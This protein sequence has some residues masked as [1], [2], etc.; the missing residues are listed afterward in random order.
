MAN[1][2]ILDENRYFDSDPRIRSV[3]R[4]LYEDIKDLPIVC[5]HGHV[6]P[7]LFSNNAPFPDPTELILI[8]DH[9]I[10]RMLYSRGIKLEDMGV[11]TRDATPN[12]SRES[13]RRA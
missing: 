10:F 7:R 2:L 11:P 4:D 8:P 3:A 12:P 9:Y 6:D 5:P 1:Q 13:S